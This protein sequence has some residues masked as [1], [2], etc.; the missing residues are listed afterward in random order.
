MARLV[1]RWSYIAALTGIAFHRSLAILVD[2]TLGNALN[3]YIW[4]V[5]AAALLAT[6]GIAHREH[7]E[8]PIHDRQTDIIAGLMV[9]GV[10]LLLHGVLLRRYTLYFSLLR[11]D[12][13]AMGCFVLGCTIVLFGLRPVIRYA[14]VWLMFGMLFP[15]PYHVLVVILGNNRM[16]A[17]LATMLVPVWA[18]WIC[19]GRTRRRGMIGAATTLAIGL[20]VL[21]MLHTVAPTAPLL[22]YQVVPALTALILTAVAMYLYARRGAAKTP[23]VRA[24]EPLATKQVWAGV[25]LLAMVAV[26]LA[27]VPLPRIWNPDDI[28]VDGSGFW[29]PLRAPAGWHQTDQE[30]YP[31]VARLYG[32]GSSFIRQKFRA[33]VG[34]PKWDKLSQPRL[35]VVDSI[36]T[37]NPFDF[38]VYPS[39]TLYP[40]PRSRVS[41]PRPVQLGSGVTA[42]LFSATD[43]RLLVTWNVLLWTWHSGSAAQRV[44]MFSVDYHED[45]AP[46]PE[47]GHS[48]PSV[49][50]SLLVV[51]FRGN[52]ALTNQAAQFKDAD[53]LTEVGRQLVAAQLQGPR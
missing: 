27:L 4:M 41:P 35:V 44:L 46:I 2:A 31:K 1:L 39:I 9:L 34:N 12:L 48:V 28:A 30:Q 7:R 32:S 29:K 43:D 11:L 18:T 26:L 38:E 5:L 23:F 51:L 13:V 14:P 52:S 53:M 42:Q 22:A 47:P 24:V 15:L 36:S 33:D 37:N 50:N 10:A 3:G 6:I 20:V 8:L 17:G 49:L 40:L 25:P 45:G 21:A 19:V 16:S